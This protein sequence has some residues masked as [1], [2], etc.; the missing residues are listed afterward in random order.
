MVKGCYFLPI[1]TDCFS[2]KYAFS[3]VKDICQPGIQ[4]E[5]LAS[6]DVSKI[7][8][9]DEDAVLDVIWKLFLLSEGKQ[10][11]SS[12]VE[13]EIHEVKAS[14]VAWCNQQASAALL[15]E[16]RDFSSSWWNIWIFS[17]LA[18][19]LFQKPVDVQTPG[20]TDRLSSA[21]SSFEINFGLPQAISVEDICTGHCDERALILYLACLRDAVSRHRTL[22]R[23]K[24]RLEA[25]VA[26]A[27]LC[28][29]YRE[30]SRR[31]EDWIKKEIN[32]LTPNPPPD[33][34]TLI[35]ARAELRRLQDFQLEEKPIREQEVRR[36]LELLCLLSAKTDG[37][38]ECFL[39]DYDRSFP[40]RSEEALRQLENAL[41]HRKVCLLEFLKRFDG[42]QAEIEGLK[43]RTICLTSWLEKMQG[44]VNHLCETKSVSNVIFFNNLRNQFE[45]HCFFVFLYTQ[46]RTEAGKFTD[47]TRAYERLRTLSPNSTELDNVMRSIALL[48]TRWHKLRGEA[49]QRLEEANSCRLSFALQ[50]S[51]ND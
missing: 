46:N 48:H 28:K 34:Q 6:T 11:K 8:A 42:V 15:Q 23:V 3:I 39:T 5:T 32:R 30:G 49:L 24:R 22:T 44:T 7:V 13:N 12:Q 14:L 45:Y 4:M 43:R 36:L 50:L 1:I 17:R 33:I 26:C 10:S 18:E 29:E 37:E 51:R 35:S 41:S 40:A 9:G 20:D 25:L 31:F 2:P 38:G 21:L 27:E 47:L 16:S 19:A